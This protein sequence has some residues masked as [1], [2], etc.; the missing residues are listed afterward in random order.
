VNAP[1]PL[2]A[3]LREARHV[4][5]FT[6]AGVSAESGLSTFRD[7]TTGLWSRFDP[8]RLA[9]AEAFAANPDVV[10]GWYEWRRLR[11]ARA[12]PNAAHRAIAELEAKVPKATVITQNVDDLHE[13]AGSRSPIRLHG[14]LFAPRCFDCGRAHAEL[15]NPPA[16]F[17][18]GSP[19]A[20]PRCA[21]CGGAIR[22]G[23]VWFGEALPEGAIERALEAARDCD[24]LLSIGT[25]G[26]VYP[27]AEIPREARR[28]GAIIVEVNPNATDL[29][30]VADYRLRGP[31][32]EI[33]PALVAAF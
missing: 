21:A 2:L 19:L 20:P 12:T 7:A 32:A 25:S 6:G 17:G 4:V 3:A 28:H 1:R 27:A 33:L 31:A 15:A 5:A 13:R 29:D 11:V 22:P 8:T 18:D 16:D 24:V 30:D 23:V 9:T 26:A 14:S 10:W